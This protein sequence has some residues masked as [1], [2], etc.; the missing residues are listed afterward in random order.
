MYPKQIDGEDM[1][2]YLRWEAIVY[3]VTL[4]AGPAVVIPCGIGPGR[5]AHGPPA[6]FPGVRSDAWLL[7][8]AHTIETVCASTDVAIEH[9]NQTSMRIG[10]QMTR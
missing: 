3:G 7:D 5:N 10:K 4:F 6:H 2:G 8:V 1:G 9:Q